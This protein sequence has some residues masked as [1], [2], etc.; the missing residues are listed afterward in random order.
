MNKVI[1]LM[2]MINED[3]FRLICCIMLYTIVHYLL[4]VSKIYKNLS[5]SSLPYKLLIK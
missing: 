2:I 1:I 3:P 4:I 5:K